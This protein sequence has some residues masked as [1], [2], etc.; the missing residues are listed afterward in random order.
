MDGEMTLFAEEARERGARAGAIATGARTEFLTGLLA[1]WIAYD[2]EPGAKPT[3]DEQRQAR[4][5][6]RAALRGGS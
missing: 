5:S 6:A 3:K 4:E 2:R 1:G